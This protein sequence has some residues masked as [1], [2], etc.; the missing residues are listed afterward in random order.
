MQGEDGIRSK[1]LMIEQWMLK[2]PNSDVAMI[3][4]AH[5]TYDGQLVHQFAQSDFRY[6]IAPKRVSS[7]S[8]NDKL[9]LTFV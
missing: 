4:S 5:S 6:P 7:L 8:K 1:R 9:S 3:L 2:Y